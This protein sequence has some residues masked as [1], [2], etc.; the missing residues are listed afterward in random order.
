MGSSIAVDNQGLWDLIK[1][2]RGQ[3]RDPADA[4]AVAA[5]AAMLLSARSRGE[6]VS[7]D[8][9]LWGL[10]A[11]SYRNPLWAAAYLINGGCSDDGF[12]Y[13]RGWLIMQGREVYERVVANPDALVD[14]AGIRAKAAS[15][16]L[17]ECED[18]LHIASRAYRAA[19]GEEFP[20]PAFR[21]EYPELDPDWDFDFDDR[22]E[23]AERLPRLAALFPDY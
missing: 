21:I 4:E 8:E 1:A 13:F 10:M 12:E 6:I 19:T 9:V 5:R 7:A 14:L 15:R 23:M 11:D 16:R 3:V 17:V 18:T 22:A 20:R 2:A